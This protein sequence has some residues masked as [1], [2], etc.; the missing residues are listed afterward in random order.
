MIRATTVLLCLS[1]LVFSCK[2]EK[3]TWSTNWSAPLVH[4]ELSITDLVPANYVSTNSASYLSI[5][6]NEKAFGISMDT[7]VDLPDTSIIEK[8]ALGFPLSINP[9][10]IWGNSTDQLYDLGQAEIKLVLAKE[11]TIT[12]V[13]KSEWGGKTTMT[14][15]FP[16]VTYAGIPFY[17]SYNLDSGSVANPTIAVDSV[18]MAGYWLDLT[19]VSGNYFNSLSGNFIVESNEPV[20]SY[21]VS[22]SDSLEYEITFSDVVVDYAK[23]YFGNYVLSDTTAIEL[24]F[25]NSVVGG[26]IDIDSI[27]MIVTIKNG[28]NLLA[29]AKMTLLRGT[30]SKSGGIVDLSFP[31]LNTSLNINPANGGLYNWSYSE[32]PIAINNS[33]SNVTQ[34]IENLSDS[35]LLGY[36]LTI[37]PFGNVTG[38]SD[39][40]FPGSTIDIF[41]NGEFPLDLGAN[42]LALTDTFDVSYS[43]NAAYTGE[44]AEI[45]IE[46]TNGFPLGASATLYLL[47]AGNNL[48]D[49]ISS[50]STIQSGIYNAGSFIT[51][52]TSGQVLYDLDAND[53]LNLESTEQ[54][55]FIVSFT[56]SS[57]QKVKIDASA[58]FDFLV[59]SNLQISLNL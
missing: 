56:S 30:N 13:M 19:G 43:G 4:G 57:G 54:I 55:A 1:V 24:P 51:S 39:E 9:G 18:D 44:N 2:K 26:V 49:S 22:T 17:Q 23:G 37:N 33:N 34:F 47:D 31:E 36:E 6:Y 59:R 5:I 16:K 14:L 27:D 29:Q 8:T 40:V 50:V 46:Y 20:N 53:I 12:F 58:S 15:D 35:I 38:G 3:T 10:F 42:N 32:Y 48:I 28:F 7:L 45:I 11:G 21:S 41:V 25:M 52:P